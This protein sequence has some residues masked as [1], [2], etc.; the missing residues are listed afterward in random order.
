MSDSCVSDYMFHFLT[1]V[2]DHIVHHVLSIY[3]LGGSPED[4][5]AAYKRNKIY[6]RPALPADEDIIRDIYN[7]AKFQ[8]YL[9]KEENYPNFLAYFQ[10]EIDAKGVEDVLNQY[11]FARDERAESLLVRL[12]AGILMILPLAIPQ[13]KLSIQGYSIRSST[14]DLAWSSTSPPSWPR[15]LPRLRSTM[16]RSSVR[17]SYLLK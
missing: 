7:T 2:T 15:L 14:L 13:T 4:I 17:F 3:A 6:Q 1:L 9:G 16:T 8:E 11:L 5:R 10:R 12:Y